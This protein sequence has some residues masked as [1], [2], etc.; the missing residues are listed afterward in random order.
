[1]SRHFFQTILFLLYCVLGNFQTIA[2]SK[3][4]P[5]SFND[6]RQWR[7]HSISLS[8]N[9]EWY[10][11]LYSLFDK[12]ESEKDTIT[13][14]KLENYFDDNNQTDILYICNS[15]EGIKY[16]VPDGSKPMFSHSSDWVAYQI[17][18]KSEKDKSDKNEKEETFIE[19][20]HLKSGFTVKYKSSAKYQFLEDKNYFITTDKTSLLIYDLDHRKEHYIGNIGEY[21]INKKSDYIAY[22]INSKDKR[23]NGIYLYNP[24]LMT[25]KA[26]E[27]GNRVYSN[28]SWNHHNTKLA[29][30]KFQLLDDEV[31]YKNMEIVVFSTLDSNPIKTDKYTVKDIKGLPELIGPATKSRN[32]IDVI[33]W[34]KDDSR[35]F[36]KLKTYPAEED[37]NDKKKKD[38]K[39]EA[40]VQIWHWKDK[41]LLS[42]RIMEYDDKKN[43]VFDAIFFR[44]TNTIVQLTGE[45]IQRLILSKGTDQWAIGTDNRNYI[46]DWDIYKNDLYRINLTTGDKTLIEEQYS[47]R[48][49]TGIEI[50][51]NGD[52]AILWD[53]TH[54]WS[55]NF[56]KNT[57]TNISNDTGISFV[58]KEYDKFGYNPNYGFVGWVKNQN[59]V[60][61]NHKL[62]LWLLP[63]DK[64]KKAQNLTKDITTKDSIRF[65][66][67]DYRFK[68]EPE[69]EDRYIDLSKPNFLYAFNMQTKHAGY[70]NLQDGK[71]KKLIYGPNGYA[72]PYRRYAITKSKNAKVIIFKKGDYQNYPEA[73]L[74]KLDFSEPKKITN[75]NPQQQ[76]FKWGKRILIDYT[77][78][79]GVPLQGILSIPEDYKKGEKSPMIV[80]SYEKLSNRRYNYAIPYLNGATVPEM[81]YVSEGYL[82]LRPDIHFNIGT[83]HSDMHESIDA[84]IEKV[85]ELGYVNEQK[86][87]YEGFSFGGHCGM[88]ISTQDNKFAAIA[89]GAGVSNL[90]QGFNIDIVRDGSN[91]QDYYMT[92]QGRLGTDPTTNTKM[93]ITE[94]PVFNAATMNTPLLLFHGTADKVVQWE[95]SFGFYSILRYLKKPVV[96]LS[97]LDEGHG[98]R[99]ESNRLD[100][101]KKLKAYFDHYLKDVEAKDW[102]I[103]EIPYI[104]KEK[105]KEKDEEQR[106]LPKWKKAQ[107]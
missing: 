45:D 52:N 65:R 3:K 69:I 68:Y 105:P 92:G 29:A 9:G 90:V 32:N 5:L 34:S 14:Q 11:K 70:Y 78:D 103:E 77:N 72:D 85:I 42:E 80:Y 26:I 41:K 59:A 67:E 101:Q 30:Y 1:M 56:K 62:D 53:G 12:P 7:T 13:E 2:Q 96:F 31:D 73:Y 35:L 63:L 47:S 20:K 36:L 24:K 75:T 25:T 97:Y 55:Y 19:L 46:S 38:D 15:K 81:L 33:R 4:E 58:D 28:L 83:P 17:K 86:I 48:Y 99:K 6:V 64:S 61:V 79:D 94:S 18:P 57:K 16:K 104:P 91:E 43:E 89:A 27:T 93:Y 66:F 49:S 23:G 74:T 8:D 22:T 44:K 95:H 84:A 102:M 76:H 60:I 107:P 98:L 50:S 37:K 71:L 51:P 10:T 39:E 54:Y 100:I 88:Y 21:V 82:F 106:T 87:G 40:T